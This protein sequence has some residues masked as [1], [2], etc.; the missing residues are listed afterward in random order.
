MVAPIDDH[1]PFWFTP[2]SNTECNCGEYEEA[3]ITG[4]YACHDDDCALMVVY[5]DWL[6]TQDA[7]ECGEGYA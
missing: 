3:A 7:R 4:T 2:E 6:K 1:S 5:R